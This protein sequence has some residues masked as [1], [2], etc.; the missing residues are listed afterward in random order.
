MWLWDKYIQVGALNRI[1]GEP[2]IGKSFLTAAIATNVTRGWPWI[3]GSPCPQGDVVFLDGENKNGKIRTR[4]EAL[5]ADL[6]R[7]HVIESITEAGQINAV[8]WRLHV[9]LT[10]AHWLR[11]SPIPEQSWSSSIPSTI[12]FRILTSTEI[13]KYAALSVPLS[14]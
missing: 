5:G 12:F 4:M 1:N 14:R 9:R 11:R 6:S 8:Q 2:G 10:M 13:T 3:D 7:A